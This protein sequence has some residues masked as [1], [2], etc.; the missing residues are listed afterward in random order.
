MKFILHEVKLWFKKKNSTPISYN[1]LPD[2][3]NVITGDATTGKTSFWSIIDYCLLSGKMNIANNITKKVSWFGIRFTLNNKEISIARKSPEGPVSSEAFYGTGTLPDIP[4]GNI[5]I[6]E[7]KSLLDKE[8]GIT[9]RLRFPYAKELGK[10]SFYHSYRYFLLFNSLTEDIIGTRETYF[11]TTFYG[12]EEY[13]Y[14]LNHVFD[15]VIGVNDIES[16]KAQERIEQIN[17]EIQRIRTQEIQKQKA[18][19]KVEYEISKLVE[20][21]KEKSFIEYTENFDSVDEAAAAIQEVIDNTKI[22]AT[23]SKLFEELDELNGKRRAIKVQISSID[24]YRKEFDI[25]RKSLTKSADSL[26]PIE[27]LTK[28]LSDQLI[29]SYETKDFIDYLGES[30]KTIQSSISKAKLEPLRVSGD[31]SELKIQLTSVENRINQLEKIRNTTLVEVQKFIAFG[32][33]KNEFERLSKG[34]KFEPIDTVKLNQLNEE[35]SRLEGE[36]KNTK[37]I[38]F[39][40]KTELNNRIQRHFDQLKSLPDFKDSKTLFNETAMHLQLIPNG[41]SFP[42]ENIGSKSNYMFMH[43]CFYLGLHEHLLNIAS[44]HVPP[45]L[46]IDQPSIPYYSGDS[47]IGNDDKSKLIDAFSLINSFIEDVV[48]KDS[49]SFQILMVE[50]APKEYWID[51]KLTHFHTVDEFLNGKGLVPDEVYKN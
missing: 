41:L 14:A 47:G 38:K 17:A 7:L 48:I 10:K 49:H 6:S 43:L 45:F 37:P 27:F 39:I 32:E 11:D 31:E 20:K 8:F 29:D 15:L 19:K 4:D 18:E 3:I 9:D 16:L 5:P 34:K 42:Y 44:Q 40:R 21:L 1:F 23:N 33:V 50:H 30:L 46:F 25:Y 24:R 26:K 2:K 13:D 22:A 12:K 36:I 51:N 35:K 28:N